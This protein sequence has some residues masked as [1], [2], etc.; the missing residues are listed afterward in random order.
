MVAD[1]AT[2]LSAKESKK[3]ETRPILCSAPAIDFLPLDL[4]SGKFQSL[5]PLSVSIRLSRL[6]IAALTLRLSTLMK[7]K[8]D[9]E[10]RERSMKES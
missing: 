5:R 8:Q 7:L 6:D 1:S 10:S 3:L 9:R 2:P 4:V